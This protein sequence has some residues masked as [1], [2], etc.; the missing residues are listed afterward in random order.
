M[1]SIM[2]LTMSFI[3][4]NFWYE[5]AA[6][7]L[8]AKTRSVKGMLGLSIKRKKLALKMA[9]FQRQNGCERKNQVL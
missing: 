7:A 2:L 4:L 6:V 9:I 8:I 3:V 1:E 5:S